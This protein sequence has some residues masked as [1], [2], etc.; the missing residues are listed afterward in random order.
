[1]VPV[2]ILRMNEIWQDVGH[3]PVITASP[4]AEINQED[5]DLRSDLETQSEKNN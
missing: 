4:E 2:G 5:H 3:L 1:M